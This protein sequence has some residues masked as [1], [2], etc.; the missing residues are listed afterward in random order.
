MVER[1]DKGRIVAGVL[2]PGGR[3]KGCAKAL[4]D[5]EETIEEFEREKGI[6]YW[7]AAT[8]IAMKLADKGN[9]SLLGK[10]LDKFVGTK[11]EIDGSLEGSG[12]TKIVIIRPNGDTSN[13]KDIPGSLPVQP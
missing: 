9:V 3:P 5:I 7:K 13:T 12:E 1:D 2:N 10:I 11:V 8:L 4:R 6:S